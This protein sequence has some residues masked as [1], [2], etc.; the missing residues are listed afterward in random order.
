MNS[1]PYSEKTPL[2][3]ALRDYERC[4]KVWMNT[5]IFCPLEHAE[6]KRALKESREKYRQVYQNEFKE[7]IVLC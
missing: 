6:A 4:H 7:H 1:C 3:L 5:S 2:E